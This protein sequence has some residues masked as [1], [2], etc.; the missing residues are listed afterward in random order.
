MLSSKLKMSKMYFFT[1]KSNYVPLFD[2][3]TILK[4]IFHATKAFVISGNE[5]PKRHLKTR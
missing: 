5:N 2:S 4:Y 3:E 1:R